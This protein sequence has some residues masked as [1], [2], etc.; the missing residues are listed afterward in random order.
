MPEHDHYLS[1]SL[2]G[3]LRSNAEAEVLA[4]EHGA[5]K[6]L[7]LYDGGLLGLEHDLDHATILPSNFVGLR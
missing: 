6:A 4:V 1:L 2:P 7:A 5:V 3:V